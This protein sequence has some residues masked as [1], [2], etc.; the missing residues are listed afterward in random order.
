VHA[1]ASCLKH[2]VHANAF[3]ADISAADPHM[4]STLEEIRR[5]KSLKWMQLPSDI[6]LTG[7]PKHNPAIFAHK[8]H[9]RH[10]VAESW[11]SKQDSLPCD[12]SSTA[13]SLAGSMEISH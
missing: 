3:L 9:R 6:M 12:M 2:A 4:V 1:I 5:W 8:A 13:L 10:R 11:A 7:Q